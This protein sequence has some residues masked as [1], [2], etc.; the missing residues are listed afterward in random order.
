MPGL[1]GTGPL[2]M[3][4]GTGWGLGWCFGPRGWRRG[5]WRMGPWWSRGRGPAFGWWPRWGRGPG[6]GLG[7][8]R[9]APGFAGW[10]DPPTREEELEWLKDEA[11]ALREELQWIEKRMEQLEEKEAK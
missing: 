6:R 7:W 3:G 10:W 8:R 1:D 4:P 2:G 5:P 11:Q 9:W